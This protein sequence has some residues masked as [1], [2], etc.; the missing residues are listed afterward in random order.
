VRSFEPYVVITKSGEVIAG[1]VRKDAPDEVV[2]GNAANVEKR[3]A[4]ADINKM[5]PDTVSVM[6]QGFDKVLTP[7]EIADVI[8][9]LKTK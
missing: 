3:I 1:I 2:L 4:R 6:P 9:F 8:A 7:E 5:R